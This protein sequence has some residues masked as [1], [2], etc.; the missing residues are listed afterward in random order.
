MTAMSV[1]F[2]GMTA[3]LGAAPL[4]VL[5]NTEGRLAF[6][7]GVGI[8]IAALFAL[9]IA[10]LLIPFIAMT[11]LVFAFTEG[12]EMGGGLL[13]SGFMALR[14][15]C[16][17]GLLALGAW[18]NS[19]NLI[20]ADMI[21]EQVVNWLAQVP[22]LQATITPQLDS[23]IVQTPSAVV[24]VMS[25]ALWMGILFG[26]KFSTMKLGAEFKL[27]KLRDFTV[28][29]TF[30]WVFILSLPGTFMPEELNLW[31]VVSVNI[32]NFV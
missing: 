2:C 17:V 29:D 28:P 12:I 24:M 21:R 14:L 8:A 13:K 20:I 19:Q 4:F 10:P 26:K 3:I 31:H 11:L 16:G 18:A 27:I 30:V 5:R 7:V 22:Q 32:F 9:N 6:F 25:V 15:C 1:L 23:L